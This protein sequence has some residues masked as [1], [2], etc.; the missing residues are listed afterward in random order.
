MSRTPLA[1]LR[2]Y[3]CSQSEWSRLS[4]ACTRENFVWNIPLTHLIKESR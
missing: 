4:W 3:F 1:L 2:R